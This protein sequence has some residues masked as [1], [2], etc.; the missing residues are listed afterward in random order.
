[1]SDH[2]M[3]SFLAG[4]A[5]KKTIDLEV[6]NEY[7][8]EAAAG[9]LGKEQIPLTHSVEKIAKTENLTPEQIEIVCQ[10]AN[11]A[12]H[13]QMFKTAENKYVTFDLADASVIVSTL[14]ESLQKT[15]ALSQNIDEDY[16]FAPQEKESFLND[17]TLTKTAGHDGLKFPE[18]FTKRAAMEKAAGSL[19]RVSDELLIL[20]GQIQSLEQ[21]FVKLARNELLPYPINERRD[22]FPYLAQF[23]KEAGLEKDRYVGLL[24][25]L[26]VVMTKQG[27]LE[28]S[29]DLKA[30]PELISDDL[31]ARVVNGTHALYIINKSL[32]DKEKR[33]E[34]LE[35][36]HNVIKTSIDDH[37][38]NGTI[39]GQ[40]VKEL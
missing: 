14:E 35:D 6:I 19:Q 37:N 31:N 11:K 17:F 7:A 4:E 10:E 23:C 29:A 20:G 30:E 24:T 33:K 32:V 26:D 38:A 39:M 3:F 12:V 9:F 27:L 28:K 22:K 21:E 8:K 16:A 1:M 15:A 40:K 5:P 13:S 18:S 2:S 25:L 34:A 36:K